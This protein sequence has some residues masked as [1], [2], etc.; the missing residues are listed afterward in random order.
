MVSDWRTA[1]LAFAALFK[2]V[3]ALGFLL[4]GYPFLFILFFY[5]FTFFLHSPLWPVYCRVPARF[6]LFAPFPYLLHCTVHTLFM[7]TPITYLL[8]REML[9][10]LQV[11]CLC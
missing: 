1:Q 11:A 10:T 9:I 8:S 3:I 5:F 7:L 6:V 2:T 4:T